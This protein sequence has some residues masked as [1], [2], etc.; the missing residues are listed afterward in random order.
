MKMKVTIY[1]VRADE[2]E[3]IA[4][5]ANELGLQVQTCAETL[6]AKS[7]V[8]A[9]GSEAVS[10]LGG[11]NLDET[12]V[13]R[14]KEAGVRYLSTR[15]VGYNHI[16]I[17]AAHR[18][19]IK[20][21]NSGYPPYGVAEFTVMLML[22]ALRK[23]KP[24]L[25]RQSVNDYSLGGLQGRELRTLRVGIIGTGRIGRA[26]AGI[27]C[28]F[29]C[30]LLAYDPYP[31]TSLS[32]VRY[33]SL[34]ALYRESDLITLHL[35]LTAD[36]RHMIDEE[37]IA[38]MKDGVILINVSRGELTQ[39]EALIRGIETQKIGALAMDVFED[40]TEIYHHRRINDIIANRSMAY[41]RQ[42]PNV[43]L[44]QHMAFYTDVNTRSMVECGLKGIVELAAGRSQGL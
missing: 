25:Y 30:T 24:A 17:E 5:Y 9:Q 21:C 41:L 22:M 39:I 20:V 18:C 38:K 10:V 26:V 14:L 35:P 11:S 1:E 12:L 34:D 16:D 8:L 2:Q 44:T 19:G 13:Y 32:Q 37:A 4:H 6:N 28:G 3:A 15:T 29:G 42:F 23:Y 31:D 40:E 27:L 36:D 43:I 33:V 7:L